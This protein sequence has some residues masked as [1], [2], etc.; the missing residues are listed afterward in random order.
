MVHMVLF[1]EIALV[2]V[3]VF[4]VAGYVSG[5]IP[6]MQPTEQDV[7][8]NGLPAGTLASRDVDRARF[9]LAFRGYRMSEVDEVLDRLRDQMA[10]YEARLGTFSAATAQPEQHDQHEA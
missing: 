3:V 9:G 7:T 5:W 10:N 4:A 2:A 6:G 8:D 1:L